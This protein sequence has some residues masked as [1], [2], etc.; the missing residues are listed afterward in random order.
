MSRYA[1][2]VTDTLQIYESKLVAAGIQVQTRFSPCPQIV[3][4]KGEMM[5]VISNL[6][7]NA[8]YAMPSGGTLTTSV[9]EA[10]ES[11]RRGLLLSV[12]DTGEGIPAENL[13]KIF[14]PFFTTR[15]S[16]G[17][18]IGLWVTTEFVKG[19]KGR[20][21]VQSSVDAAS[22]GTKMSIF[23]PFDGPYIV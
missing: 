12:E 11:D 14:E 2:L 18:G 16:I 5:Q 20:I 22:H 21:D 4:R 15:R 1:D 3:L 13:K 17:T 7:A 23:L 10:V 6:V 19:H 9:E 8:I